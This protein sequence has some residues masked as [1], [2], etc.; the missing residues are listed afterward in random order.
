M[1]SN[2]LWPRIAMLLGVL[3]VS[4]VAA[5]DLA[6]TPASAASCPPPPDKV[7]PFLSWGDSNTYVLATGGSFEPGSA[8]WS[9]TGGA[10]IVA[11]DNA[12]NG[13][14][15]S[16]DSRALYLPAGSSA[17]SACVTAPQIKSIVRF[18]AKNSGDSGAS[19][20]VEILVKGDVYLAGSITAGS[21]WNPTPLLPV[22]GPDYKGAVT[23]QVRLT[24]VG[25]GA[26]FT[27]DDVYFDPYC[28]R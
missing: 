18:F 23:Y 28:S 9:L 10:R 25:T 14:D 22:A 4:C 11:G 1:V 12:P 24:A 5:T 17:T 16:T 15:P 2:N 21:S 3:A 19:L 6:S 20:K 26:A 8:A 13:L 7:R 27:V